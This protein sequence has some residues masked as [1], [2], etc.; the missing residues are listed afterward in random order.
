MAQRDTFLSQ[1]KFFHACRVNR[2][3]K[4]HKYN[5]TLCC[6]KTTSRTLQFFWYDYFENLLAPITFAKKFGFLAGVASK[7]FPIESALQSK[8]QFLHNAFGESYLLRHLTI[9][10]AQTFDSQN[11]IHVLCKFRVFVKKF[12]QYF[13]QSAPWSHC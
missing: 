10:I 13:C 8:N 6:I 2:C 7:T 3:F 12:F 9:T 11:T 1:E 4:Y 5:Y